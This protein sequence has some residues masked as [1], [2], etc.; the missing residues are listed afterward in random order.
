MNQLVRIAT[1]VALAVTLAIS[2]TSSAEQDDTDIKAI[3]GKAHKGG[4]SIKGKL[5]KE[6]KAEKPDW[7]SV[8]KL[9]DELGEL[10]TA[11]SK[12]KKLPKGEM[13]S[14]EKLTKS[15][16]ESVKELQEAAKKEDKKG[17]EAAMKKIGGSCGACHKAHK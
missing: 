6:L 10:G 17:A 15:Y 8:S 7:K 13:T 3:M 12:A 14:W 1:L 2:A 4:D 16:N 11:L 9:S 5:D